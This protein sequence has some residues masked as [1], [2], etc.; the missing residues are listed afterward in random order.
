VSKPKP[1]HEVRL[2]TITAAVWENQTS[3]GLRHNVTVTR[4]FKDDTGWKQTES[5][6]RDDLPLLAKVVDSAHTWIFQKSQ[7]D[8]ET[9]H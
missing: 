9:A 8:V 5:F 2:G 4:L 3:A 7:H 6:G 1:V